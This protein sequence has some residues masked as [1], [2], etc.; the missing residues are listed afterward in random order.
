[1]RCPDEGHLNGKES[2]PAKEIRLRMGLTELITVR[3]LEELDTISS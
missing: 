2:V 3:Q 1:M